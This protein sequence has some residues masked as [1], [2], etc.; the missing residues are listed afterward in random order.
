M[1][2]N[3][4]SMASKMKY[5]L[6]TILLIAV[7]FSCSDKIGEQEKI[8]AEVNGT[9]L[10]EE[11][12]LD[13]CE[14]DNLEELSEDH[15]RAKIEEWATVVLLSREADKRGLTDNNRLRFRK[16]MAGKIINANALLALTIANI[17]PTENE[18]FN[19]YQIHKNV[20]VQN[21]T[22][23]RIQRILLSNTA[24]AD[25]V[26]SM[27]TSNQMNFAEAARVYSQERSR[28]TDGYIGY[29]TKEEMGEALFTT[30][31]NLS[32]WRFTRIPASNGIYLVR[33]TD[34]RSREAEK[35]FNDVI[36][37]VREQYLA[38]NKSDLV[39]NLIETL[40]QE[41]EIVIKK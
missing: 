9:I 13:F 25:S 27:L 24:M 21:V 17:E 8:V 40:M 3:S 33:Y 32:Q 34:V 35:S 14:I 15:K 23:Y 7:V 26:S 30:I 10:T 22:E 36:E 12:F 20:Y 16:D 6:F 5:L 29:L 2:I 28:E 37:Q 38:E 4:G 18:L 41:A 19:Y 39:K 1:L 31:N 11:Q